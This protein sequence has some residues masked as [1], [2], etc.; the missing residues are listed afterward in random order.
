MSDAQAVSTPEGWTTGDDVIELPD[1]N[2]LNPD[3][4]ADG[5]EASGA[6]WCFRTRKPGRAP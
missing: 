5:D 1:F 6:P 3:Q 4:R 2:L